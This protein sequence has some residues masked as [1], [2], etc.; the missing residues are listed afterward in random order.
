MMSFD[1][2]DKL[3]LK[4]ELVNSHCELAHEPGTVPPRAVDYI[5]QPMGFKKSD[6]G[7]ECITNYFTI[8]ICQECRESLDGEEWVIFICSKCLSSHWCNR[9]HANQVY[10]KDPVIWMP[11]GCPDCD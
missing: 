5:V 1:G 10:G 9:R 11:L 8:P 6:E 7:N 2:I 4:A 3:A